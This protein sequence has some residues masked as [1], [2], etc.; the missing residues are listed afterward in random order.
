MDSVSTLIGDNVL[1]LLFVLGRLP[2]LD[3]HAAPDDGDSHGGQQVVG[4]VGVSVDASVEHGGSVLA[5]GAHDESLSTGVVFD[6]RGHV[7]HNAGNEHQISGLGLL[8][9]L[10]KLDHGQ[11]LDGDAPVEVASPLVELLLSLLHETLLDG[12]LREGLQIP[13]QADLLK[14]PDEP[15]GGVVLVPDERV[16]VVRGELVVEVVVALSKGDEGGEHVVSGGSSVV[17]GLLADPVRQ[18]VD[19]ERHLLHKSVSHDAGVH[20]AALPVAPAETTNKGGQNNGHEEQNPHVVLVLESHDP[21]VVEIRNVGSAL[22]L[23]VGHEQHPAKVREPEALSGVIGVLVGVGPSVVDSVRRRPPSDG[24]LDGSSTKDGKQ[25]SNGQSGL[26]GSVGPQSMVAGGD[27]QTGADVVAQ[28]KGGG[29]EVEGHKGSGGKGR[30]RQRNHQNEVQ[31]VDVLVPVGPGEGLFGNVAALIVVGALAHLDAGGVLDLVVDISAG[32]D[33][34]DLADVHLVHVCVF[35]HV[36]CD[37]ADV[38]GRED[39]IH[40]IIYTVGGDTCAW[41]TFHLTCICWAFKV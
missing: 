1:V 40:L 35:D 4:G 19:A 8:S 6:K 18:R 41:L 25:E 16:S 21:V 5:D 31:P 24:S 39:G 10:L 3:L 34:V 2:H 26:V 28:S 9:E 29:L 15:L 13:G 33:G 20:K 23:G 22:V 11:L 17:K 14:G 37:L 12:V 27:A 32:G 7:V 36:E 38:G 30:H